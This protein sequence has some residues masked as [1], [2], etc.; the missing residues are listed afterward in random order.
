MAD[1][2]KY[3]QMVAEA[4]IAHADPIYDA[5]DRYLAKADEDLEDELKEE[6]YAEPKDTVSEINSLEEEIADILHSQTTALVTALKAADGDWDAAQEN[7]SDMIDEDDIAEQVTEAA[8]A[9]YELNIPKLATVY[10]QESDGELVV[11]TLRQRT[12]EWFA[13]WSEQ[14]GNLM[15][16][17]THKQITDLIQETIANGDDIATLTRKI[18]VIVYIINN[19]DKA[20]KT[21]GGMTI[22]A[23]YGGTRGNDIAVACVAEAGASTFAVR[24][25]LGADKVEEYTGLTTIAD[26]IAVNSG[27]YVVFSATST[28]ANLTAFASTNLES[29]TDG[30]VQNTDITAFLDASEKIKWNTMAFPKDE[31]SQKTAVI[32]KIKYLREQCGKTV[33]AVLPDAESDYEGII[34]VTNSYAVDG[35]ELTNAQ[36]CAWVAGATAG[37][38]K[39]TSNTYVAVEGATDVVGLKTNEEAI[40][41][42][43]NGEFFFSISEEDEVIVEYDINSLHKFTTERT[44]DYSKNRVIRVYDSF[45]DDLKLTF[46]P[47]KFD[48]D[49]D[50]WLVMEGLGRALL[51]SYSKQ[52]AITNVDAENDFYVDQSKSIGDE[53]FFNVGLQAVDSAEKLYFSVSTR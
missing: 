11:D 37:A 25:Y 19:G 21:A 53:T 20:T 44:S 4:I 35:Q 18:T 32:T 17:N 49:P 15:K 9:M 52:G 27:K 24:V 45:A 46:P 3:Y 39:T 42:I 16:V 40:E 31:S 6:G 50:G 28:S 51:Q 22:T 47:N 1:K 29:G 14:L 2:S 7:V 13:S 30:A 12:S 34:N 10:I 8:N 23:A 48:N 36:A 41:A 26:L 38:D 43:S 5:I 33:Q